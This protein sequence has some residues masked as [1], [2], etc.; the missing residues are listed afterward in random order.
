MTDL[1]NENQ[2]LNIWLS[3]QQKIDGISAYMFTGQKQ[4]LIADLLEGGYYAPTRDQLEVSGLS[5]SDLIA[6]E[7]AGCGEDFTG[8]MK[9]TFL[10]NFK[11]RNLHAEYRDKLN[12]LKD[13]TDLCEDFI[14]IEDDT[15]IFHG[16]GLEARYRAEIPESISNTDFGMLKKQLMTMRVGEVL[17]V[18]GR[19]GTGK[20]AIGLQL[21]EGFYK[22]TGKKSLFLSIEMNLGGIC[23]RLHAIDF[24]RIND[25]SGFFAEQKGQECWDEWKQIARTRQFSKY[26]PPWLVACDTGFHINHL[27]SKINGAKKQFGE[28]GIVCVDYL[29][30]IKGEG[31]DRRNIVSFIAR[32]LKQIAKRC[33]VIVISLCQTSRANEDG[34]VPVKLH[35]LKESGDI[36][37]ASDTI[38]GLWHGSAD[39]HIWTQD[40]KNRN[41]FVHEPQALHRFGVYFR[42]PKPDE[43]YVMESPKNKY[44][45]NGI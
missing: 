28:I 34:N 9:R 26:A 1:E 15:D 5:K 11:K 45:K 25:G 31:Q 39:D 22:S 37:E 17:T 13:P 24:Y 32:E 10:T 19:S 41:S 30:L 4:R 42:D 33:G 12:R 2:I 21:L 8:S 36:E 18:A 38:I 16:S 23:Q 3:K 29:Q 43:N 6:V 14:K 35:H 40:I 20:T 27:E 7:E 44:S